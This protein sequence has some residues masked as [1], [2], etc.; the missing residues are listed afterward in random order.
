MHDTVPLTSRTFFAIFASLITTISSS[1]YALKTLLGTLP[2]FYESNFFLLIPLFTAFS[3]P[4]I[5]GFLFLRK[6]A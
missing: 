2:K 5:L 1:L 4:K 6:I 3:N